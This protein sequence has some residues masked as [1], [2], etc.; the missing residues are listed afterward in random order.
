MKRIYS[1]RVWFLG[2]IFFL[3][4]FANGIE[5]TLFTSN[6]HIIKIF[7]F[8]PSLWSRFDLSISI[9]HIQKAVCR[10]AN[11]Y[12]LFPKPHTKHFRL[13]PET[14]TNKPFALTTKSQGIP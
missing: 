10:V 6:Y 3:V 7:V 9:Q 1:I 11:S 8:L 12:F 4:T 5:T 13:K 14:T 2:E